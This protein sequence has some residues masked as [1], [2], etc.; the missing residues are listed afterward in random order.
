MPNPLLSARIHPWQ[1]F[2]IRKYAE[3]QGQEL[4]AILTEAI[5]IYFSHLNISQEHINEWIKEY[6]DGENAVT[7]DKVA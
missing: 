4:G 5:Q 6:R 7:L 3:E 1:N 2:R